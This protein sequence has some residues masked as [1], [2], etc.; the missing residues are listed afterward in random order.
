MVFVGR[1]GAVDL[2]VQGGGHGGLLAADLRPRAE[3]T[4]RRCQ[5]THIC[6]CVFV[7]FSLSFVSVFPRPSLSFVVY[8][9]IVLSFFSVFVAALHE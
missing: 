5:V 1:D 7:R 4:D 9:F 2:Q 6:V 8:P 3:R